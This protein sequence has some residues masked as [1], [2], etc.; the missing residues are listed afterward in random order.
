MEPFQ[1]VPT[2]LTQLLYDS[3]LA[4]NSDDFNRKY[5]GHIPTKHIHSD[6]SN[7]EYGR[8]ML[9]QDI[10]RVNSNLDALGVNRMGDLLSPSMHDAEMTIAA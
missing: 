5:L 6:Y 3:K 8:D 2:S 9:R 7:D 4:N 1:S 10:S